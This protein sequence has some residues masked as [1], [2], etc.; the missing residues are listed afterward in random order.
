MLKAKADLAAAEGRDLLEEMAVS[1]Q[2]RIIVVRQ[3]FEKKST[4]GTGR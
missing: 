1:V 2:G 4:I 3:E